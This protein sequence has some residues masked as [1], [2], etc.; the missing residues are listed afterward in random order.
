MITS[1][2]ISLNF[3]IPLHK[4]SLPI[5]LITSGFY[6]SPECMLALGQTVALYQNNI[7]PIVFPPVDYNDLRG[8]LMGVQVDNIKNAS[9]LHS[10]WDTLNK[11][12]DCGGSSV[13]QE[14]RKE[15]LKAMSEKN[16]PNKEWRLIKKEIYPRPQEDLM[17]LI[18]YK[19]MNVTF[20]PEQYS[21]I[22]NLNNG[23]NEYIVID[24]IVDRSYKNNPDSLLENH[25][26]YR[27][28]RIPPHPPLGLISIMA[29]NPGL[30]RF[31]IAIEEDKQLFFKF[32]EWWKPDSHENFLNALDEAKTYNT[33]NT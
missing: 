22:V 23:S 19:K 12:I 30:P 31:N 9:C 32:I 27:S 16:I 1:H 26:K 3:S 17:A 8:M 11:K 14:S 21:M 28:S 6:E 24:I 2:D 5:L 4:N 10:L 18:S 25:N 33:T 15:L 13:W 20:T 7:Y 29:I